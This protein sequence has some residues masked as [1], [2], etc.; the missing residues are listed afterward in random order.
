MIA[1]KNAHARNFLK[2]A[3]PFFII[4]AVVAAGA[5]LFEGTRYV[6]VTLAVSVLALILF[7][8]GFEKKKTGA[9]RI[10]VTCVIAA[11]AIIGRLIPLFKP[12][13]AL[14]AICGMYLGGE[15]G[16]LCGALSALVSNFYFGHGPWTPF[17]MLAWGLIGVFAGL[18]S[19]PLKRSRVELSPR[20][21]PRNLPVKCAAPFAQMAQSRQGGSALMAAGLAICHRRNG[22]LSFR[23][24]QFQTP[25]IKQYLIEFG[26]FTSQVVQHDRIDFS[27]CRHHVH[28][29]EFSQLDK[30]LLL[31]LGQA[32]N[33]DFVHPFNHGAFSV[34]TAPIRPPRESGISPSQSSTGQ[35]NWSAGRQCRC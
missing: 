15:A 1:I 7:I 32:D 22:H 5:I 29:A 25:Q 10:V 6:W 11:L 21:Q 13:A 23:I 14:T 26:M 24:S 34:T 9:R 4:P 8:S 31:V 17:Q 19:S 3:L 16:F 18:L 2:I 35:P 20:L 30:G 27:R 33:R 12:I 28:G